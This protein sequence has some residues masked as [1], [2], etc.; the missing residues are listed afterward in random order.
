MSIRDKIKQLEADDQKLITKQKIYDL[1]LDNDNTIKQL[2]ERF[3]I[4]PKDKEDITEDEKTILKK[5]DMKI[6]DKDIAE[7]RNG[8]IVIRGRKPKALNEQQAQEIKADNSLTQRDLAL[9][10]NVSASTINKIK[11]NKYQ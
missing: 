7:G 8:Y 4:I 11:N 2:F 1:I 10:Y 6:A 3:Y 9:K 5:H